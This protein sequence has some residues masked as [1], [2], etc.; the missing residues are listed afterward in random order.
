MSSQLKK[1][2]KPLPVPLQLAKD[3]L[4]AL[5]EKLSEDQFSQI[6]KKLPAFALQ[7]DKAG[8][9]LNF[10]MLFERAKAGPA[11]LSPSNQKRQPAIKTYESIKA[12]L[13][14]ESDQVDKKLEKYRQQKADQET[15]ERQNADNV[16]LKRVM[17]FVKKIDQAITNMDMRTLETAYEALIAENKNIAALK[18]HFHSNRF[19][20]T[21]CSNHQQY[22]IGSRIDQ[23]TRDGDLT[24]LQFLDESET[25]LSYSSRII[26]QAAAYGQYDIL[27]YYLIELGVSYP[28]LVDDYYTEDTIFKAAKDRGDHKLIKY[29]ITHKFSAID[30]IACE[31]VVRDPELFDFAFQTVHQNHV[32]CARFLTATVKFGTFDQV[33]QIVDAG[34]YQTN[35][36]VSSDDDRYHF[37][38]WKA[39]TASLTIKKD[40]SL[41]DYLL[42]HSPTALDCDELQHIFTLSLNDKQFKICDQL[43]QRFPAFIEY[44]EFIN[45]CFT[46][47]VRRRSLNKDNNDNGINFI[48]YFSERFTPYLDNNLLD[49]ALSWFFSAGENIGFNGFDTLLSH[50]PIE[51]KNELWQKI[52][53]NLQS[54]KSSK[55]L[56]K[57]Y[58]Y[59]NEHVSAGNWEYT[60]LENCSSYALRNVSSDDFK[61]YLKQSPYE[62]SDDFWKM[63]LSRLLNQDQFW[64]HYDAVEDVI[65]SKRFKALQTPETIKK[66]ILKGFTGHYDPEYMT[67][68]TV[69][70]LLNKTGVTLTQNE[71]RA[72]SNPDGLAQIDK[73][74]QYKKNEKLWLK[75]TEKPA[76][77]GLTALSPYYYQKIPFQQL[78]PLFEKEGYTG[79]SAHHYA[80]QTA[81]LFGSMDRVLNYL[82]K[83][84]EHSNQ[85]LHNA[86]HNI[87]LPQNGQFDKTAW[88][89][90]ILKH[91]PKMAKLVQYADKIPQPLK[92]AD[93]K[94]WSYTK[95]FELSS[96]FVYKQA[97]EHPE[98]SKICNGFNL[99]E[100]AFIEALNLTKKFNAL[101]NHP[102]KQKPNQNIPQINLK[103]EFF[104][105][106]GYTLK[107]LESGDIRSLYLGQYTGCCQWLGGYGTD[108][109][110]HGFTSSNGGFY[111]VTNDNNDIVAQAWAWRG[112]KGEIVFDSLETRGDTLNAQNWYQIC[113]QLKDEFS[114]NHKDI[115]AFNVG[116]GGNTPVMGFEHLKSGEATPKDYK[117]Y[118]DS[119]S[120]YQ[121]WKR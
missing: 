70:K 21:G 74:E 66:W 41:F 42:Q 82:D 53:I 45:E 36:I 2:P 72:S 61:H 79:T 15:V 11:A 37:E 55:L 14:T 76:P 64:D 81:G 85:P 52:A 16:S 50:Y 5:K 31:E 109:A 1:E 35:G 57:F 69:S 99:S 115:T 120:Q 114:N 12:R 25:D 58:D 92:T 94:G 87:T 93:G 97:A 20:L 27:D 118:R 18:K 51:D 34:R 108:C 104:G 65:G 9:P 19:G 39:L 48:V 54:C 90:A 62:H 29:L 102:K 98:L 13:K 7:Q 95:T 100:S 63:V 71:F 101:S 28:L 112:R 121:V 73:I 30:E 8:L 113:E 40:I 80:Y 44:P 6:K 17:P 10:E 56:Q 75:R 86:I 105:K 3:V 68:E 59:T 88:A 4:K 106:P 26:K 46:E 83:W 60:L 77:I 119:E 91:G 23:L 117:D 67:A 22:D 24:R 38:H 47:R 116:T 110:K 111:A 107:R 96:Q 84:G 89:D 43:C 49:E 103:G 33:K 78:V 32:N